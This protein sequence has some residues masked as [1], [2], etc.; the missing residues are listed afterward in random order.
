MNT[1]LLKLFG[2]HMIANS[3][4]SESAKLQLL[5]YIEEA[6]EYQVK[7]FLLDGELMREPKDIV[8][9]EIVDQRFEISGIPDK[10]K[11]F[12]LYWTEL[13]S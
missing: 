3:K 7:A 13:T 8:C 4:L 5:N 6:D 9:E 2:G 1:N 10:L 12:E 11:D